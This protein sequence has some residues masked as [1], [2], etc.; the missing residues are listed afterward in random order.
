MVI[1]IKLPV[2]QVYETIKANKPAWIDGLYPENIPNIV[3]KS[4]SKTLVLLTS[5]TEPLS[6]YRNDTFSEISAS[7]QV[8]IFFSKTVAINVLDAQLG[9]MNLLDDNGWI[10]ATRYPNVVDPYTEQVTATFSVF[11]NI[12]IKRGN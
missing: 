5:V 4:G 8:Q 12:K 3:D 10:I 11:K 1:L 9:L 7:I 6:G 2:T